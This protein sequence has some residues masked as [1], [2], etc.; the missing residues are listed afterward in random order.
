MPTA[1]SRTI[2][3]RSSSPGAELP[4]ALRALLEAGWA[5]AGRAPSARVGLARAAGLVDP[6]AVPAEI[7]KPVMR[8]LEA[9]RAAACEPLDAKVVERVLPRK[10]IDDFDPVPLA[11]RAAA[12]THRGIVGGEP[13]A[14]RLRRP[15]L[16]RAVR[17]DLALLDA[18][19]PLLGRALPRAD[20]T[21][22][23]RAAREQVLDEL[24]F[25]HEAS[26]HRRA[27]RALRGIDGLVVPRVHSELC[28]EELFVAA[29]LEG[30]SLADGA[31]PQDPEGAA[32]A[33]VEAHA[34]A[35]RS[36]LALMDA[37][38]GHVLVLNDGRIGL[39]GVGIARAVDRGHVDRARAAAA[40]LREQDRPAFAEALAELAP[41]SAYEVAREALGPL[42]TGRARLDAAA[43]RAVAEAAPQAFALVAQLCPAPDDL[44]LGR[45][46]AQL[47]ATLAVLGAEHDWLALVASS[48]AN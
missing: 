46:A 1:S 43:L 25:E 13:V 15:G 42:A 7:R 41:A 47:A 29:L 32:R 31:R 11:V 21:R 38:P 45:A 39:L 5:L 14:I 12:Q 28:S 9:A 4:P 34:R 30:A 36:G 16:E 8:E 27:A 22:L 19:A 37:R 35:A 17:N 33:L 26:T 40:A 18:I 10:A 3:S 20:A 23:L 2:G 44:W 24:D 6:D 48:A